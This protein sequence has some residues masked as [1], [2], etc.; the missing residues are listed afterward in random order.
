MDSYEIDRLAKSVLSNTG[1]AAVKRYFRLDTRTYAWV[2]DYVYDQKI[3]EEIKLL[4]EKIVKNRALPIHK[5]ELE[6]RFK[7]RVEEINTF[8]IQQFKDHLTSVQIRES[9]LFD[10]LFLESTPI[11]GARMVPC[12]ITFSPKEIDTIFSELQDG[13]RQKDIEKTVT[14][15]E[16][17]ISKLQEVLAQEL[18]PRQRW[19][20]RD[21]GVPVPYPQGCRWTAFVEVWKKVVSRFEGKVDIEGSALETPEEHEAFG[22]LR[23]DTVMKFPPLRKPI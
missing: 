8:R 21:D 22:L 23:L 19:Y 14:G 2:K 10:E 13:V 20:Y 3:R 15:L 5:E 17:K 1:G 9:R 4:Q 7:A 6:S 11:N 18:N 12:L 16:K